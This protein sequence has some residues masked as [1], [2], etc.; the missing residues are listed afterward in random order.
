MITFLPIFL[1][2]IDF[3]TFF[4]FF[5]ILDSLPLICCFFAAFLVLRVVFAFLRTAMAL[6]QRTIAFSITT[7]AISSSLAAWAVICLRA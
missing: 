5:L 7:K 6:L 2:L 3:L 1:F 4:K